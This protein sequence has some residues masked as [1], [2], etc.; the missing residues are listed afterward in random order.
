MALEQLLADLGDLPPA[1][2]EDPNAVDDALGRLLER[3]I[4]LHSRA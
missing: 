3:L 4:A 1:L 2:A